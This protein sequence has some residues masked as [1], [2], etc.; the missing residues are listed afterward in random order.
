MVKILTAKEMQTL[1]QRMA[2]ILAQLAT[3]RTTLVGKLEAIAELVTHQGPQAGE[4]ILM[5]SAQV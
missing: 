3:E 1:L 4:E 5:P 2:D